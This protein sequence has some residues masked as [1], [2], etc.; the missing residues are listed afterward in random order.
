V[1]AN[2]GGDHAD[3]VGVYLA[4]IPPGGSQNLG[5]CSP[6][7]VSNLGS[8][9]LQPRDKLT[10]NIDPSWQCTNPASVD[11]LPW[12]LH[13]IADVHA[14]DLASCATIQQVL[15]GVCSSALADDDDRPSDDTSIR[16]RPR[17]VALTP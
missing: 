5:G 2:N 12:T 4:F 13:A 9:M 16:L 15:S 3:L 6:N 1:V 11:G 17:V 14:N 10:I 8:N 7:G